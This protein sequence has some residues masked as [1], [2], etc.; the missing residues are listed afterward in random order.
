MIVKS[1]YSDCSHLDKDSFKRI[2]YFSSS[3]LILTKGKEYY[4]Y[5]MTFFEGSFFLQVINDANMQ[6]WI[7]I[8]FFEMI[9]GSV[10][11]DWECNF[12][13]DEPRMV[14]GP[15]FVSKNVTSYNAM[16]EGDPRERNLFWK[17]VECIQKKETFNLILSKLRLTLD[18]KLSREDVARWAKDFDTSME[19]IDVDSNARDLIDILMGFDVKKDG[20][21]LYDQEEIIKLLR[22]YGE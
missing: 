17:R 7:P 10:E 13:E 8:C 15:E 5:A 22:M 19:K 9:D 12:F 11:G 18:G 14:M 21:Y 3:S 20:T 1:K 2:G 4:V 6:D 16:V